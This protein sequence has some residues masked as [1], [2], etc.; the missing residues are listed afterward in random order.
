MSRVADG[1]IGDTYRGS[2]EGGRA[3][4]DYCVA[5]AE[6][7]GIAWS[8]PLD[9]VGGKLRFSGFGDAI[10]PPGRRYKFEIH[11]STSGLRDTL[12]ALVTNASVRRD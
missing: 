4:A 6:R 7:F 8:F 12:V 5:E 11:A 9:T 10:V 1:A 3:P 2:S